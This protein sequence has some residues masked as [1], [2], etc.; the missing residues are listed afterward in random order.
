[1]DCFAPGKSSMEQFVFNK[2][3]GSKLDRLKEKQK[4]VSFQFF[5]INSVATVLL[6]AKE[7]ED[8]KK[9]Y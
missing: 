7:R 4:L 5:Q 9:R 8:T 1:M 6:C 2:N 3:V